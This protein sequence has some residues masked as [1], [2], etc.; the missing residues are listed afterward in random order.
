MYRDKE[1][2]NKRGDEVIRSSDPVFYRALKWKKSKLIFTCSWSDFFIDEADEWRDDAWDVIKRTPQHS[3]Q[4]LT[5]RPENIMDRLPDD[6]GKGYKNVWLG[7]SIENQQRA[8]RLDQLKPIPA[9]TKFLSIEPLIGPVSGLDYSGIDWVIIGGES[10]IR[11]NVRDTW[12]EEWRPAK[13]EWI[14]EIVEDVQKY[15][16]PIFIK[17]LGTSLAKEMKLKDRKGGSIEDF[18][19][20][21]RLRQYPNSVVV[22]KFTIDQKVEKGLQGDSNNFG[23]ALY[24]ASLYGDDVRAESGEFEERVKRLE[25]LEWPNLGDLV[26]FRNSNEEVEHAGV[27]LM[28]DDTSCIEYYDVGHRN[29][30]EFCRNDLYELLYTHHKLGVEF[31]SAPKLNFG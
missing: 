20:H 15:N 19:Y 11:R 5:K 26:V 30:D 13:M 24:L 9:R 22:S 7:V 12:V 16:V 29:Q 25:R 28:K 10:G 3:W 31:Y 8:Y 1:R 2:Y 17:Q 4:I 23:T 14:E 6:W 27:V 21:L 18:P